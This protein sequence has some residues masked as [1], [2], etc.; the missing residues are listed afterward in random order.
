[1]YYMGL[2]NL[3]GLG[4]NQDIEKAFD[5]FQTSADLKDPRSLNALA[6]IYYYAPD[7]FDK[8]LGKIN[9]FGKIKKDNQKAFANL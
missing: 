4:R 1:M 8:D 3:L 5:Y 6:Y 7:F 9:I 2:M